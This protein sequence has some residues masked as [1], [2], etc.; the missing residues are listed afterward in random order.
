MYRFDTVCTEMIQYLVYSGIKVRGYG[1]CMV[2]VF[3][4]GSIP[5]YQL[6]IN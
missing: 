6:E 5:G 4:P 2:A 3:F 1:Y